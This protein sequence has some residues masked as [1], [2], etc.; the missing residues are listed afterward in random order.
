MSNFIST[1]TLEV[2]A[3]AELQLLRITAIF[4]IRWA[5]SSFTAAVCAVW[6]NIPDL[7]GHFKMP[8][9]MYLSSIFSV[10]CAHFWTT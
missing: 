2:A 5:A 1:A 9:P 8:T 4:D 10:Q 7:H 3:D 6:Q